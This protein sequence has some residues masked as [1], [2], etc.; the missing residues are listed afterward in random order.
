[1][2]EI[3]KVYT[4][5]YQWLNSQSFRGYDPYDALNTDI[6]FLKRNRSLRLILTYI[7]KFSPFN[8]RPLTGVKKSAGE[9]ALSLIV[10]ALLKTKPDEASFTTCDQLVVKI[11]EQSLKSETGYHC[12]S[13]LSFPVQTT[14]D[15]QTRLVPDVIATEHC[16]NALLDYLIQH[17]DRKDIR[18]VLLDIREFFLSKLLVRRQRASYFKYKPGSDDHECVF[19]A[20]LRAALFLYRLGAYLNDDKDAALIDDCFH[21]AAAQQNSDGSW[22]YSVNYKSGQVKKQIDF[23]Q[24]FVLDAYLGIF[25]TDSTFRKKYLEVCKNGLAFYRSHQFAENGRGYYRYPRKW[26]IDIHNQAQGIITFSLAKVIDPENYLFAQKVARYT[27]SSFKDPQGFFY[28]LKYPFFTNKI[29]Y[30]RWS[31][32][33]ML[34]ALSTLLNEG[35]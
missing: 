12:W 29:A 15:Y 35:A 2:N 7:F 8:F 20:S 30:L 27:I 14:S 31:Q 6:L 11:L 21:S 10:M 3:R 32:A 34:L 16:G 9:Q 26:P 28:Y 22:Y 19:N 13:G 1:M 4:E 17:P 18:D 25:K 23:H 24:G 5:L 33:W